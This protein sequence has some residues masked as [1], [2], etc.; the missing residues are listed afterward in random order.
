MKSTLFSMCKNECYEKLHF[1][2][3]GNIL[4]DNEGHMIHIDYGFILS[5]SPGR[6]LGF[7][8]SPFKLTYEE[9][10]IMGGIKSD[11]F[12][13]FKILILQGL[14]AARKHMDKVNLTRTVSE[15]M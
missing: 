7:E 13:Y 10:E 12:E 2:H 14:L 1:R 4:L 15:L 9:V 3:N 8:F 5:A 11:M 6:N